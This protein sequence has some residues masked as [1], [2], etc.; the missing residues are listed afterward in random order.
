M[1]QPL[2]QIAK[3]I[4]AKRAELIS[5]LRGLDSRQTMQSPGEDQW[6]AAQVVDHLLLAEGFTNDITTMLVNKARADGESAGFPPDLDAFEPL[7]PPISLEAP[8]PIRS[9]QEL[10]SEELIASLTEMSVRT[11]AS[12]EALAT[13]DPRKYRM[14]HPLFGELDLGQWWMVHP[15]HYEMHI[16]QAQAAL[17]PKS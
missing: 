7:P 6:N 14:A 15:G 16:M 11:H 5:A 8:P 9:R 10:P 4:E 13:V 2:D 12:F 3:G 1:P 17:A